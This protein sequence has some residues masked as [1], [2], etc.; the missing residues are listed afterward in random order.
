[1]N[2]Y[3]DQKYL[4]KLA[5]KFDNVK[6]LMF[7]TKNGLPHIRATFKNEVNGHYQ[8]FWK[9][10]KYELD[11]KMM[12]HLATNLAMLLNEREQREITI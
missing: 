1:M 4:T 2:T 7:Y 6:S 11:E 5:S 8:Y 10:G 3:R 9:L 12:Q